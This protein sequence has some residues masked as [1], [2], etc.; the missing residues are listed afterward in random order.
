M[1]FVGADNVPTP[2]NDLKNKKEAALHRMLC[3]GR[4]ARAQPASCSRRKSEGERERLPLERDGRREIKD[5][6]E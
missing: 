5:K 1:L 4:R 6:G 3:T 2:K